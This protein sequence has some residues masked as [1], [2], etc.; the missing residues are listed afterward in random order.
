VTSKPKKHAVQTTK[1][2]VAIICVGLTGTALAQSKN[3]PLG[4]ALGR[5]LGGVLQGKASKADAVSNEIMKASAPRI[6]QG[7]MFS[8]KSEMLDMTREG[9]F[10]EMR[11]FSRDETDAFVESVTAVLNNE[12]DIPAFPA[13]KATRDG[14]Q[15]MRTSTVCKGEVASNI[16]SLFRGTA[17]AYMATVSNKLRA[18]GNPGQDIQTAKRTVDESLA[19]LSSQRNGWCS[20]NGVPHPYLSALPKLLAEFDAVTAEVVETKRSK[21]QA[22]YEQDQLDQA[23]KEIVV[24]RREE[25][26]RMIAQRDAEA[27]RDRV[28]AEQTAREEKAARDKTAFARNAQKIKSVGLAPKLLD[29]TVFVNYVG[30]WQEF[31]PFAQWVALLLDNKKIAAVQPISWRGNPGISIKI[32]GRPAAA[33]FF[34]M[35]GREAYPF[36]FGTVNEVNLIRTA[37]EQSQMPL[38]MKALTDENIIN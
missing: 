15:V 8:S 24:Q 25:Q 26:E 27:E 32:T 37:T 31:M 23:Q 14:V 12:Y 1:I 33:F 19:R 17:T 18:S 13:E 10:L 4:Q 22:Q 6:T 29:S 28:R 36:A 11:K 34:R 38:L 21:L 20:T 35:E 7:S 30:T 9:K 5:A 3:D 2:L 16:T